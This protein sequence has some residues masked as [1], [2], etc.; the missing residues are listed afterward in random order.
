VSLYYTFD[1]KQLSGVLGGF[2]KGVKIGFQGRNLLTISNYRG[3]DP[4]VATID[5]A[6]NFPFD[7]FGYPN[8]RTYTGSIQLTF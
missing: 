2:F 8:F 4:E 7:D 6:T 5:D 1:E 3:Y